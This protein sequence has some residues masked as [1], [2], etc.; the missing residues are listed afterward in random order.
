VLASPC[1]SFS[2]D[3]GERWGERVGE[4]VLKLYLLI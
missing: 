4:G 2:C 3:G 1:G